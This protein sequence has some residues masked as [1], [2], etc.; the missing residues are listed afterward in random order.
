MAVPTLEQDVLDLSMLERPAMPAPPRRR[1]AEDELA[2]RIVALIRRNEALDDFASLVAH[3]LKGPLLAAS[4]DRDS[5]RRALAL[6]DELLAVARTEGDPSWASPRRSLD[7]AMVDVPERPATLRTSLPP[8]F[9]LPDVLLRVLLRNLVA[10]A[11]TAG[12]RTVRIASGPGDDGWT[13]TVEDD[14]VG[15]GATVEGRSPG[16][17][18]GLQLCQRI[19]E[20]RG[21]ELELRVSPLGGARVTVRIPGAVR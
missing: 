12:A 1:L 7:E 21:G 18:I 14:G 16:H 15:F 9:P 4:S 20:R 19:A 13:L 6:V 5:V 17:G 8:V 10:N 2:E 11:V 3:E